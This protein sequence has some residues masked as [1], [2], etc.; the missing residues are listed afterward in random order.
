MTMNQKLLR[1]RTSQ[2]A[3]ADPLWSQVALLLHMDGASGS[4][5]FTDSSLLPK[6]VTANGDA[7]ISTAQ[8]KFGG[9]SALFDGSGD[10]LRTEFVFDWSGNFTI[11]M[12]IRRIGTG[13]GQVHTIFEAGNIQGSV[14]GVHLYVQGDGVL[15]LNN[16]FTADISGGGLT[17]D[18]WMHVAAV[19]SSGQNTL[20]LDG[21]EVGSGFQ[22]YPVNQNT[23]S[24]GGAP[25]Y[26]FWPFAYI[27]EF[28]LTKAARYTATFTPPTS[29][30]PNG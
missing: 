16:G 11:E 17:L 6:T 8:S 25:N 27:D 5:T 20:Y 21:S 18:T 19:R 29:A 3:S 7:Q 26:G 1:P 10:Y 2:R 30:F 14:G 23:M 24:I 4:T 28:R 22:T 12:W 9:S 13:T 15:V